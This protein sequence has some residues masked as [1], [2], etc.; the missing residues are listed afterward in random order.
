MYNKVIFYIIIVCILILI[1]LVSIYYYFE[2][3]KLIPNTWSI[4]QYDDRNNSYNKKLMKLNKEY[5]NLFGYNY[6]FFNS[7][8]I[9]LPPY[10]IKVYLAKKL[11]EKNP[12]SKGCIWLDSDAVIHQ[13]TK[14]IEWVLKEEKD[15][16]LCPDPP[17]WSSPF[18]AGVWIVRNTSIGKSILIDWMK[19]YNPKN[20]SIGSN[21]KWKTKG[22][23]AGIDYE[24]GSFVKYIL[25][26]YK[27]NLCILPYHVL[28]T[29]EIKDVKPDTFALHFCHKKDEGI[30]KYLES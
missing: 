17:L 23:W 10:W 2:E 30:I 29:Q 15:F 11:L 9:S 24:Q 20:W 8:D 3:K 21:K 28:Q 6:L 14:P 13:R 7:T 19:C 5:C 27:Y 12:T 4:L 1:I 25:P 26:K 18:N 16:Y 22:K